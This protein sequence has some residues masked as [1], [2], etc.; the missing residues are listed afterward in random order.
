MESPYSTTACTRQGKLHIPWI[1]TVEGMEPIILLWEDHHPWP[2]PFGF[3][4]A[5]RKGS[6]CRC[7]FS[8]YCAVYSIHVLVWLTL[9]WTAC[10]NQRGSC[11]KLYVVPVTCRMLSDCY[12]SLIAHVLLQTYRLS[13]TLCQYTLCRASCMLWFI[14]IIL[15]ATQDLL[16][17]HRSISWSFC[18]N[19]Y[20]SS[21]SSDW[22]IQEQRTVLT[23]TYRSQ[24][25]ST[26][27]R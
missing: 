3:G 1:H 23:N 10:K 9:L 20:L 5:G 13:P 27:R 22:L 24:R 25:L 12:W 7:A 16:T 21:S 18:K 8:V 4:I 19:S 2:G 11:E 17:F 26:N 14:Y 6:E 15:Q